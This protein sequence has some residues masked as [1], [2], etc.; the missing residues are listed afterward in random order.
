VQEVEHKRWVFNPLVEAM[1]V[2]LLQ[3]LDREQTAL[4]AEW[5]K[6]QAEDAA[7]MSIPVQ[8]IATQYLE[9]VRE[10]LTLLTFAEKQWGY[11]EPLQ[12][13]DPAATQRAQE[14]VR[15][16]AVKLA[17]KGHPEA[18][19]ETL[20][21]WHGTLAKLLSIQHNRGIGY[22][23]DS[24]F[25]VLNACFQANPLR[26]EHAVLCM[27]A[28]K[29]FALPLNDQQQRKVDAWRQ[30]ILDSIDRGEDVYGR[31]NRNDSILALLFP[32]LRTSIEQT[33]L[34]VLRAKR[35]GRLRPTSDNDLFSLKAG[36][37]RHKFSDESG[38]WLTGDELAR[39]VK[40][41]PDSAAK[42]GLLHP[43]KAE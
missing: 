15:G 42:L 21:G 22:N 25:Q 20:F 24:G 4:D 34:E 40:D 1:R 12:T 27:A 38:F 39:W 5:E 9:A 26:R 36:T 13:V 11:L 2:E 10:Y 33:R 30:Q 28:A 29:V 37:A 43:R 18:S 32:K 14:A 17:K 3:E 7:L 19:E 23:V 35:R 6:E 31:K 16:L 8:Q 41:N